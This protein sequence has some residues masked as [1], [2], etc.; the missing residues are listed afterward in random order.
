MSDGSASDSESAV[1]PTRSLT[2]LVE[3]A[4]DGPLDDGVR[5][6]GRT[7]MPGPADRLADLV[8]GDEAIVGVVPRIPAS[9]AREVV[10]S[11]DGEIRLVLTGDAAATVSGVSGRAVR[12]ALAGHDVSVSAHDG[13]S[14]VGVLLVGDRAVVGLFDGDGLAALLWTDAPAVR[15]WAADTYRRYA[16][17]AAP[18]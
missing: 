5:V 14:P 4:V 8:A 7:D 10:D 9:L 1:S 13:D 15:R 17:A 2:R 3:E 18:L 6:L 16:A 11:V 12:T